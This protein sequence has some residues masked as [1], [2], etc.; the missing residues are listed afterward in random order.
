MR[1]DAKKKKKNPAFDVTL[2]REEID[3]FIEQHG[4]PYLIGT[5]TTRKLYSTW[6]G[7]MTEKFGPDRAG[8]SFIRSLY[9]NQPKIKKQY[10]AV[11]KTT[12]AMGHTHGTAMKDYI[13]S[14]SDED[15]EN[16]DHSEPSDSEQ[17]EIES[18]AVDEDK[19]NEDHHQSEPSDT[20]REPKRQKCEEK[21]ELAKEAEEFAEILFDEIENGLV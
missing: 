12:A 19:E 6:F 3:K 18:D 13:F 11:A 8:I 17:E 4:R 14:D 16:E 9:L 10:K 5:K 1:K 20:E 7:S 2:V 15:K 21:T